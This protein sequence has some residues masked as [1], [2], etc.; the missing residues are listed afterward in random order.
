MLVGRVPSVGEE[1]HASWLLMQGHERR[2][3]D[4]TARAQDQTMHREKA[5]EQTSRTDDGM[6]ASRGTLQ[7]A[8]AR[9]S[10]HEETATTAQVAS[11]SLKS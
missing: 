6:S 9:R 1:S 10:C 7:S 3:E 2:I 4:E 5:K 11:A 8:R